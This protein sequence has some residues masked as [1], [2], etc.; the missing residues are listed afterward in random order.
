[1]KVEFEDAYNSY[2]DKLSK[3]AKIKIE[4]YGDLI[5]AL[6]SRQ[7]YFNSMGCKVSDHGMETFYAED[8]S[9]EEVNG[10][11]K[12]IRS[13]SNLQTIE[14]NKLKSSLLLDLGEMNHDFGWTQQFHIGPIRNNN[15]RMLE[16]IGPDTGYDSIGDFEI[17]KPMSKFLN[18]LEKRKKVDK[19][20]CLQCKST[21]Q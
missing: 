10:I 8:F 7:A 12:K 20:N 21:R 15:T 2:L 11:F 4:A 16:L 6:K 13:G 17:A 18:S 9:E 14:I 1:M 5:R 3:A 19:N